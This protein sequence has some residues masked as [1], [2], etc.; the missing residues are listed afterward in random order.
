MQG[1]LKHLLKG[2]TTNNACNEERQTSAQPPQ[3]V[4]TIHTIICGSEISVSSYSAAKRHTRSLPKEQ[5]WAISRVSNDQA[6]KGPI[7]FN[8][9]EIQNS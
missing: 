3:S 9:A 8:D 2:N 7:S 4:K 5:E 6:V 1:R